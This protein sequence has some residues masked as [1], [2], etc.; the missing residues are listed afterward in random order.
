MCHCMLLNCRILNYCPKPPTPCSARAFARHFRLLFTTL[1][2]FGAQAEFRG[3][4]TWCTRMPRVVTSNLAQTELAELHQG[5]SGSLR[6]YTTM[7]RMAYLTKSTTSSLRARAKCESQTKSSGPLSKSPTIRM[8]SSRPSLTSTKMR[9][10]HS[11]TALLLR[12]TH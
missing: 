6:T 12:S 7:Q 5:R 9:P 1:L 8:P 3:M 2:L 4:L 10:L 11:L